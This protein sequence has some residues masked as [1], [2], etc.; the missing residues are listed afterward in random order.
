MKGQL[1]FNKYQKFHLKQNHQLNRVFKEKSQ[2]KY[3]PLCKIFLNEAMDNIGLYTY[4]RAGLN[5]GLAGCLPEL[6]QQ[7]L[8]I[9][10]GQFLGIVSKVCSPTLYFFLGEAHLYFLWKFTFSLNML[11][12]TKLYQSLGL[13]FPCSYRKFNICLD[14]RFEKEILKILKQKFNQAMVAECLKVLFTNSSR[15][16]PEG[17]KFESC[18]RQKRLYGTI[19]AATSGWAMLIK[20]GY[21]HIL[22]PALELHRRATSSV[23]GNI[24]TQSVLTQGEILE[25]GRYQK[26]AEILTRL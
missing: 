3:L 20:S 1:V 25:E 9:A 13:L 6:E 16:S 8:L 22:D 17:P 14:Q 7:S 5:R 19:A 24:T 10:N 26:K 4:T 23:R 18:S 15:E 12:L 21:S 11:A 2:Q